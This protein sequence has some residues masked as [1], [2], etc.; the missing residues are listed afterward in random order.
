MCYTHYGHHSALCYKGLSC[1]VLCRVKH[2]SWVNPLGSVLYSA[3]LDSALLYRRR[4]IVS[5]GGAK[6]KG[7]LPFRPAVSCAR[8]ELSGDPMNGVRQLTAWPCL[9]L[10]CLAMPGLALLLELLLCLLC[11]SLRVCPS[12]LSRG[13]G[14]RQKGAV[15]CGLP[16]YRYRDPPR[17]VQG[18][19]RDL[20]GRGP[21]LVQ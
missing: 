8:L 3:R 1:L 17:T 15:R 16:Q 7:S 19:Y 5:T 21:V 13:P 10:P 2:T 9:A 6:G 4:R 14:F 18:P 11:L 12:L 20:G